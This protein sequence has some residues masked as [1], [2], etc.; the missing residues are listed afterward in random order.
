MAWVAV[1]SDGTE[2]VY[3]GGMPRRYRGKFFPSPHAGWEGATVRLPHGAIKKLIGRK[4]SW[5][6]NPVEL[7]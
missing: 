2:M 4:L 5:R 6:N 3:E 7:K 1:D